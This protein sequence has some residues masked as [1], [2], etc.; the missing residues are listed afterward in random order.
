[1]TPLREKMIKAMQLRALAES[2]QKSYVRKVAALA[3]HYH[4]SPD[5]LTKEEIQEY[6]RQLIV[7]RGLAWDTINGTVCALR[8]LYEQVLGWDETPQERARAGPG[9]NPL[10]LVE[11]ASAPEPFWYALQIACWPSGA[12][13]NR[14]RGLPA[15]SCPVG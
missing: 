7:D 2:T 11:A 8:L 5:Q 4:R 1:M 6:V 12:G 13:S 10:L 15:V 9:L 14:I 3:R